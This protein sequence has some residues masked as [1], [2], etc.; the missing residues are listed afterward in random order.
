MSH[1]D[2]QRLRKI[3]YISILSALAFIL[4][5]IQFPLPF[6]PPFLMLDL[7]DIP[8]FIGFI[9]FGGIGG[10]LI[11]IMKIVLYSILMASEPIGP[12][13]NMLAAFSFLLPVYFFYYRRKTAKSLIMGFI[14]GTIVL[15]VALAVLNYFVLLP[16]YGIIVDQTDVINNLRTIIT[17]GI[18][19]FN[20][21][22]GIILSL[23]CYVI[24]KKAI[25]VLMNRQ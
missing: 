14:A 24:Y 6:L 15:T 10:S 18:I 20:I 25:P 5:L 11:I 1:L 17:A 3:I 19:P 8:A 2:R 21:V 22:K 13:A 9:L 4:M 7:S 16:A 23:V 12:I